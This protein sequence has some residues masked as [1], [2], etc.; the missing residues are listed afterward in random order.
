MENFTNCADG[1]INK[2]DSWKRILVEGG[3]IK[4]GI[5]HFYLQDHLGN[6]RVVAKS[7]GTVIQTEGQED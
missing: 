1:M 7:D 4:N 6:N 3:Y 5:Y 2:N